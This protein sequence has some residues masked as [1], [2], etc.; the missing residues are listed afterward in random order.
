MAEVDERRL[1]HRAIPGGKENEAALFFKVA[2]VEDGAH[3][4]TRLQ[5]DQV[6]DGFALPC[7]TNIRNL[8]DLQPIDAALVGKDE[9]VSM[10]GSDDQLLD[11]IFLARLH[12]GAAGAAAALLTIGADR[13]A[14]QI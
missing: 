5:R 1:L 9:Q 6:G 13:G 3:R 10:G 4:F 14:L 11:K 8:I 2:N 12:S 7:R